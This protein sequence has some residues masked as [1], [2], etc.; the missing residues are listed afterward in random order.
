[1]VPPF[2]KAD[3]D[4]VEHDADDTPLQKQRTTTG[5]S[6]T[7]MACIFRRRIGLWQSMVYC[8]AVGYLLFYATSVIAEIDQFDK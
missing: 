8:A 6:T 4:W 2:I 5:V 1:M 7:W 3:D